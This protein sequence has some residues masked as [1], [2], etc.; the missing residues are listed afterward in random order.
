MNN[1]NSWIYGSIGRWT[2]GF[3][4]LINMI[5]YQ[6][7]QYFLLW[8]VRLDC[9]NICLVWKVFYI[10]YHNVLQHNF[11]LYYIFK[12]NLVKNIVYFI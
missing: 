10:N 8:D 2:H 4:P 12:L 9:V 5:A 6:I 11:V 7:V 3:V 1:K